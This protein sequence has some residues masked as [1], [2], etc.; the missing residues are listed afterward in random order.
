MYI[1][2]Y[3]HLNEDMIK[4]YKLIDAENDYCDIQPTEKY[5]KLLIAT[6]RNQILQIFKKAVDHECG[7]SSFL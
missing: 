5:Y 4:I 1:F 6:L 7:V 3:E 2:N